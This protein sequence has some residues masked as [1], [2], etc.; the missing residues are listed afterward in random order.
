MRNIYQLR[1]L[2]DGAATILTANLLESGAVDPTFNDVLSRVA[3]AAFDGFTKTTPPATTSPARGDG[4]SSV[5]RRRRSRLPKQSGAEHP[6]TPA[7]G[8]SHVVT[9][10]DNFF[11]FQRTRG[12]RLASPCISDC[13]AV[14]ELEE[15]HAAQAVAHYLRHCPTTNVASHIVNQLET[16]GT[17]V[18]IDL[19]AAVQRG[20][21]AC[22]A[23]HVHED[24]IVSGVYYS[25]C[26]PGCAPLVLKSP[27]A[28]GEV[29]GE[30]YSPS[31]FNTEI[32]DGRD[33]V[34]H[35]EEGLL[36]LFPPW[37]YHG[38]P[39][40]D[41]GEANSGLMNNKLPRVSWAFNLTGRLASIGDPWSVTHPSAALKV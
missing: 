6:L 17:G 29:D 21:G 27:P 19:W 2:W 7:G 31:G 9:P 1:R 10:N 38:V 11:E 39:L 8:D 30:K 26:P 41:K 34:I 32:T 14:R 25:R 24:T 13:D 16:C 18:T 36:L 20:K 4:A 22:H 37:L 40:A 3:V 5:R 33:V 35:P 12:Y 15:E 23:Y 28:K